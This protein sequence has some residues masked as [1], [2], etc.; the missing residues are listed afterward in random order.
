MT[1]TGCYEDAAQVASKWGG[2]VDDSTLH[3]LVQRVGGRAEEQTQHR[4]KSL[5]Q[6]RQPQRQ[7]SQLA[8]LMVDGWQV[9]QR[10][11][12]WGKKK[13]KQPHVQW[14]ELKT[15]VFYLHE[16]SGQTAGGR[17]LLQDKVVIS[18]QGEPSE[19]GSR[20]HWEAL[21]HGL[22]RA[23]ERLFLGDG[24]AWIWN[25]KRDRWANALEL[26]DFFHGS[27]HL[28]SLGES[29]YGPE[30]P[31]LSQWVEPRLHQLRH[32]QETKVLKEISRLKKRRGIAG[33]VIERERRYF[34]THSCRMNYQ[35]IARRGWPIGSGAVESACRQKQCRFKR[36]GQFWTPEG[37]RH[38]CALDE[39]RRNHHWDQ[40]WKPA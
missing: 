28:W 35:T 11:A 6:E 5:P 14:H 33:E 39:A 29:W 23:G 16:Q 8:V 32:G 38:L 12:G 24:A 2:T 20:L 10:G 22:G 18:W 9:R 26:L 37:L 31:K 34:A 3:A 30:Q 4:L 15:G 13:S 7:A 19:L 25:L 21:H 40:L 1:A 36:P 27:Q 17:G